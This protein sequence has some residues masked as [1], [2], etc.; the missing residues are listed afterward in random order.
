MEKYL[1][2]LAHCP[3]FARIPPEHIA[4]TAGYL[5]PEIKHL[6]KETLLFHTGTIIRTAGIVLEGIVYVEKY[7]YQGNIVLIT[8]VLQSRMFGESFALT[9]NPLTVNV[10]TGCDTTILLFKPETLFATVPDIGKEETLNQLRINLIHIFAGKNI[11]LTRRIE[12]LSKRTIREKILSYLTDN[13]RQHRSDSF[14]IPLNRQEMAD[15]LAVDRSA[16]SAQLSRLQKDGIINFRKNHFTLHTIFLEEI[17]D[18]E[19]NISCI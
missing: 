1:S 8:D 2:I 6:D 12:H 14:T 4:E 3:L 18:G 13:A 19:N 17:P 16:L 5:Q 15:Y 11:F 9:G 7:D 10:K